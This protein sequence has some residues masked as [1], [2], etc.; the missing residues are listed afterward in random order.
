MNSQFKQ[1]MDVLNSHA[2]HKEG[3]LI[4]L[5]FNRADTDMPPPLRLTAL[6]ELLEQYVIDLGYY[7]GMWAF[8]RV[9]NYRE[10]VKFDEWFANEIEN[11]K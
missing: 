3:Y 5:I 4:S 10:Q 11:L 6:A 9:L 7:Q 1:V 2:N 8:Y